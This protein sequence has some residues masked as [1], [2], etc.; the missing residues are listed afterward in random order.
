M[1]TV[2][3]FEPRRRNARVGPVKLPPEGRK[4]RAPTWPLDTVL[5]VEQRKLWAKLWRTPQ[6]VEWQRLGWTRVVARYV[7]VVLW[8][9][10]TLDSKDLAQASALEDRLGLTPKA[11]RLL[12][13]TIGDDDAGEELEQQR[14]ADVRA[15]LRAVD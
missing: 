10:E 7:R 15:R 2:P 13:W 11:M 9:E 12:L 6:A 1:P 5:T 8:A 3:K 14:P 4:G